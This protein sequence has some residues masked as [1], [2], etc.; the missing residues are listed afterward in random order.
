MNS[1][2]NSLDNYLLQRVPPNVGLFINIPNERR[3][4]AF[5]V[6]VLYYLCLGCPFEALQTKR[7]SLFSL[8]TSTPPSCS[9][10]VHFLVVCL[11]LAQILP[12]EENFLLCFRQFVSS[13][14]EFMAVSESF[15]D[16]LMDFFLIKQLLLMAILSFL[17]STLEPFSSCSL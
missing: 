16:S 12:T 8:G 1:R 5:E 3:D 7:S 11:Q 9:H 10:P 6:A 17:L 13:S 14:A 2:F 4:P 15:W